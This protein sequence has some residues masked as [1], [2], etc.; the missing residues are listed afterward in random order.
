MFGRNEV[1]GNDVAQ[2]FQPEQ[3]QSGQHPALVGNRRREHVVECG[4]PVGSDNH[5]VLAGGINVAHFA[6]RVALYAGQ[7]RFQNWSQ[8]FR[9]QTL[10]VSRPRQFFYEGT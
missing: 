10:L 6:A 5:Q 9:C 1:V 8:S 3:R 2:L 7:I 4:Q